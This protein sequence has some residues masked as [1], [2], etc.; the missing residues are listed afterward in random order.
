MKE[1]CRMAIA[2][3]CN[4]HGTFS[5][6]GSLY[7]FYL[8]TA[9][10]ETQDDS[11]KHSRKYPKYGQKF[12]AFIKDNG[13][14]DVWESPARVNQA[15]HS[16]HSNQVYIWMPNHNAVF[17]WW[18]RNR[19]PRE[20]MLRPKPADLR[21]GLVKETP[22]KK[23][24]NGWVKLDNDDKGWACSISSTYRGCGK[25]LKPGEQA[26]YRLRKGHKSGDVVCMS[27]VESGK[28]PLDYLVG[29][30]VKA[31]SR[32]GWTTEGVNRE[33]LHMCRGDD[34]K[35]G[36]RLYVQVGMT[37]LK[38]PKGVHV[39]CSD[40]YEDDIPQ[41]PQEVF[42]PEAIQPVKFPKKTRT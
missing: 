5:D 2:K 10:L 40:C 15:F 3:P 8:F 19:E 13:L 25:A 41:D 35:D 18:E 20:G 1:F 29:P 6:S 36:C 17:E 38:D 14:G 26:M 21:A 16:D 9:A 37:I 39:F 23:E 32:P 22:S 24:I 27:C 33:Y 7:S 28:V 11:V 30:K 12:A 34:K 31:S 42:E 4:F